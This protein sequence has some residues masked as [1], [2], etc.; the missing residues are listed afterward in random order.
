MKRSV[1]Y[2]RNEKARLNLFRKLTNIPFFKDEAFASYFDGTLL[3]N[4]VSFV[5]N[6][7]INVVFLRPQEEE[8]NWIID[9]RSMRGR[10]LRQQQYL[11]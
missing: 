1:G 11:T 3:S 8:F 2:L 5:D 7:F 10:A 4:F 6:A 9:I